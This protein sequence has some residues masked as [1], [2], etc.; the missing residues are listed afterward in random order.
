MAQC[1][2]NVFF[3]DDPSEPPQFSECPRPAETARRTWR[4]GDLAKGEPRIVISVVRL[5][6]RCARE[7]DS[8]P[9]HPAQALAGTPNIRAAGT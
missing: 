4:R 9:D 3:P 6:G 5:C 7:W 2:S 1:Q 8:H